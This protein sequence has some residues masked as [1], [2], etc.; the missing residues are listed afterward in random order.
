MLRE[1][2]MFSFSLTD[3][4]WFEIDLHCI[5]V[6]GLNCFFSCICS[7]VSHCLFS[8]VLRLTW[9]WI[10]VISIYLYKNN[11]YVFLFKLILWI[12]LKKIFTYIY[13]FN[14]W[15]LLR[16][17]KFNRCSSE[18]EFNALLVTQ[19]DWLIDA[20]YL[21]PSAIRFQDK[22]AMVKGLVKHFL[23]NRFVCHVILQL[24]LAIFTYF[25]QEI[26]LVVW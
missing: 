8:T 12:F 21:N 15:K 23:F 13:K 2:H 5:S 9:H 7:C 20:G 10:K 25:H 17:V 3:L 22:E 19:S 26:C 14:Q 18:E 24:T 6:F 1:L 11:N 4:N 16:N